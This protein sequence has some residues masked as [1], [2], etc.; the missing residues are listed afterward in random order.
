MVHGVKGVADGAADD[1]LV[2]ADFFTDFLKL[3][4]VALFHAEVQFVTVGEHQEELVF[5]AVCF[6]E[7]VQFFKDIL[8]HLPAVHANVQRVFRVVEGVPGADAS[9]R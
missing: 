1:V 4:P 5:A 7:T 2:A 3:V 8:L 9:V 6:V